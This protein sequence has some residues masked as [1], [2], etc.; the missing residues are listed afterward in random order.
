MT[1]IR[2]PFYEHGLTLT[3]ACISYYMSSKVWDEII[4]FPK[5][6]RLNQLSIRKLQRLVRGAPGVF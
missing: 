1:D 4:S 5:L 3:P 6:Q 2:S